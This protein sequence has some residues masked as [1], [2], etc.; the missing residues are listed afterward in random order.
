MRGCIAEAYTAKEIL[1]FSL[2]YFAKKTN[3]YALAERYHEFMMQQ[4]NHQVILRF[5][6]GRVNLLG[7]IRHIMLS[8]R[9]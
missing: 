4:K 3:V 5:F 2:E 8:M 9:S 6:S 7:H 1:N